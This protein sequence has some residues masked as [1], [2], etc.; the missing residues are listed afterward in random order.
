MARR[1]FLKLISV[2]P[3]KACF[4]FEVRQEFLTPYSQVQSGVLIT[5]I[6]AVTFGAASTLFG[7]EVHGVSLE[8]SVRRLKDIPVGQK[9]YITAQAT[10]ASPKFFDCSAEFKDEDGIL[11]ARGDQMI[12]LLP[13]SSSQTTKGTSGSILPSKL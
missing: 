3:S 5:V 2:H 8:M 12:Y 4:E 11:L 9:I 13:P 7:A 1:L 6:D 10:R